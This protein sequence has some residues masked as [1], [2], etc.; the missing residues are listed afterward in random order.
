MIR[1]I[2]ILSSVNHR[3]AALS[4]ALF[5]ATAPALLSCGG[6][7]KN[8]DI[9]AVPSDAREVKVSLFDLDCVE[10]VDK[11]VD[12]LKKDGQVYAVKFDKSRV[13]L[14]VRVAP[15]M[16]PDKVLAAV[17]RAGFRAELGD[18]GGAW[19]A[20]IAPPSAAD[21]ATPVTDGHDLA[22]LK[23]V[24]VTGK[25]TI[26]DFYAPW[27]GPCRDVDKHVKDEVLKKR[28]DVAYRR[29]NVVD[30]DSP[31]ALHYMKSVKSLPYVIVFDG[32]GAQ[33]DA[34]TGLDLTR[35]DAAI[36]KAKP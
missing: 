21:V 34:I 20:D 25:I 15:S 7:Q 12:E 22:D 13:V 3:M 8:P 28:S 30:W 35:L 36:A 10:C 27:C 5:L 19:V 29:I 9:P 23:T 31:I 6:P 1:T 16:G 17:K 18:G 26:V 4:A 33:V 24:L 32:K 11:V 14:T 2:A